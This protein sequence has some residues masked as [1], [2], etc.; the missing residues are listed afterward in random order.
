MTD[1]EKAYLY[2]LHSVPGIGDAK[3][4]ALMEKFGT[5]GRVFSA[6]DQKLSAVLMPK[7]IEALRNKLKVGQI[8]QAYE[9][10]REKGIRM[11]CKG[12]VGYP[13]RLAE[14]KGAPYLLYYMGNLPEEEQMSVAVIGARECSEYGVYI[15]K[16]F[17]ERMGSA[18][19]NIISGMARGI[20]SVGQKAALA[21]GGK[22]YAVLGSG[23][24]VCYPTSNRILYEE[25]KRKGGVLSPYLPGQMPQ[26][27]LFPYRNKIVAALA[28][29]ILVVEA[30]Q[31]SGT[32]ITV[33]MALE[34]GKEVYAV[35]G[36]LTDR[37]SDGCNLLIKQGAGVV[38]SPEDMLAE[39]SVLQN[40]KR[41]MRREVQEK[42]TVNK[43]VAESVCQRRQP[44]E[45]GIIC[46]L[47]MTPKSAENILEQ[48]EKKDSSITYAKL[49]ALLVKLCMEGKAKRVEGNYFVKATGES[50]DDM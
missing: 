28:D 35:P 10:I 39:I 6:S 23:V 16:A 17:A 43:T 3:M 2:S 41:G 15:A 31:K 27:T 29:C 44:Q 34:Q 48:V 4:N 9:R 26:K 11:T 7:E 21:V 32:W 40:R 14:V 38:L 30:R 19:V 36:R 22:S 49:M 12:D 25:M 50:L 46:F 24:D 8:Q 13:K 37:L 42:Q 20:D 33:D 47:D 18:G 5:A 45:E 1:E